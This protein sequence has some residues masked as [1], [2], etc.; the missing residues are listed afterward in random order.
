MFD[1]TLLI[2]R[3]ETVLDALE[4]IPE[5]FEPISAPIDFTLSKEGRE[6]LDAICMAL[7][8]AG[9]EFKSIDRKT[10]G[11]YLTRYPEVDWR[12]V[13]GVRDVIAHGYFDLD[14]EE[15]FSIRQ[16]DIPA[17]IKTVRKMIY[18]LREGRA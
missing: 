9:E 3:L 2:D 1:N 12:G 10:G 18:D 7:A 4:R 15:V 11:N 13:K 5:R 14:H 17:L 6:K 16:N 8:A